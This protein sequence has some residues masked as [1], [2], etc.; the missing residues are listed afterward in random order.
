M[1]PTAIPILA[2]IRDD[3]F[4][5]AL[6]HKLDNKTKPLGSL[7]RIEALA[8]QQKLTAGAATALDAALARRAARADLD[9]QSRVMIA[10]SAADMA[11]GILG[12][13]TLAALP[14]D[15]C[16]LS[17]IRDRRQIEF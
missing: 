12:D 7:G 6:Q 5:Q 15:W 13:R 14:Y 8:L 16:V 10:Q 2:D 3:A 1:N 9:P 17:H 4:T 11:E